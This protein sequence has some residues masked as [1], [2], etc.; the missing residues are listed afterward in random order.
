MLDFLRVS[1][2][3]ANNFGG[4]ESFNFYK[5]SLKKF[6]FSKIFC[7]STYENFEILKKKLLKILIS[8]TKKGYK[9][10]DLEYLLLL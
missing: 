1:K 4:I 6:K 7:F 3:I 2:K 8:S 5:K 10:S 9:A